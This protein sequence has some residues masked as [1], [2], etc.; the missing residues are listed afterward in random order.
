MDIEK[1]HLDF[2]VMKE[3]IRVVIGFITSSK[4]L[5]PD[6]TKFGRRFLIVTGSFRREFKSSND[7][8]VNSTNGTRSEKPVWKDTEQK[9]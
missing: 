4:A 6:T 1:N 9:C 7:A 5:A 2:L 3:L 8:S